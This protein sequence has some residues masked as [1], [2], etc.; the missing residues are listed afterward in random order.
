MREAA[1]RRLVERGGAGWDLV[2]DLA[3]QGRLVEVEYGAHRYY[4]RPIGP[5]AHCGEGGQKPAETRARAV[6]DAAPRARGREGPC[7]S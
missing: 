2:T 7:R 5:R 1:V 6:Q 3:R 4:L